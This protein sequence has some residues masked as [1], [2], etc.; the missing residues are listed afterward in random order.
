MQMLKCIHK[1]STKSERKRAFKKYEKWKHNQYYTHLIENEELE[2]ERAECTS[3]IAHA[4][5]GTWHEPRVAYD[6]DNTTQQ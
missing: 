6:K 5:Q 4:E 1:F 3:Y 2:L